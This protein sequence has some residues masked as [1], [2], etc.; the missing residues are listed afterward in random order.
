[1][2]DQSQDYSKEFSE[3]GFWDKVVRYA[4]IAGKELIE[5]ALWLYYAAQKKETPLWAKAVIYTALGYFILPLDVMPDP[6][7]ADDLAVILAALGVVAFYID[8]GVKAEAAKK[9][10]DWFGE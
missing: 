8:A 7:F 2:T 4:K 6:I 5:K 1:M 10:K 9:L 3:E